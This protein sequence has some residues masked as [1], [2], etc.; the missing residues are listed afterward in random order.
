MKAVTVVG[1]FG[2]TTTT[3]C[4][5]AVFDIPDNPKLEGNRGISLARNIRRIRPS[6]PFAVLEAG[7][8]GPGQMKE[9]ADMIRP[10]VVV[11]TSIGSEHNRSFKTLEATRREK[12]VMVAAL[13][14]RCGLAVFNGDDE[15][16]LWMAEQTR[17]RHVTYSLGREN[18][19]RA[20]NIRLDWPNRT[21][22][23]LRTEED[24]IEVASPFF[25]RKMIYPVLAAVAVAREAGVDLASC[26]ARIEKLP[27]FRA[28]LQP[29][30]LDSGAIVLRDDYKSAEEELKLAQ[31]RVIG[32]MVDNDGEGS[33][34][35]TET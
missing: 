17:A 2:K 31:D 25:G 15:N 11:V 28:R 22:F 4:L 23:T 3:R 30:T 14:D 26:I 35:R 16:V 27:A 12:S 6:D 10:D 7:I 18:D 5:Y 1:S 20:E 34:H 8:S 13:D 19:Y 32:Y 21:R 9:S 33:F 24:S 29:V